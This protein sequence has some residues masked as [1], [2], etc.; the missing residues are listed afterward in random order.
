MDS[1]AVSPR[2]IVGYPCG[3]RA[4]GAI[5]CGFEARVGGGQ[6]LA[7]NRLVGYKQNGAH[8]RVLHPAEGFLLISL[9]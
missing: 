8:V 2:P 9:Q 6:R 5:R 1:A 3:C 4:R 7:R